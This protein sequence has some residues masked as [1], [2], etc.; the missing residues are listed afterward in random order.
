MINVQ[1]LFIKSTSCLQTT[2]DDS[3]EIE[4]IYELILQG[5]I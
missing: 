3:T 5:N 2:I 4:L 1:F